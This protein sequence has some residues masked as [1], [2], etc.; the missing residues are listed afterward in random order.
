MTNWG[1]ICNMAQYSATPCKKED[2]QS[3]WETVFGD[4]RF[5]TDAFFAYAFDPDG[6]FYAERDGKAVAALYLLPVLSGDTKGFYLYAA[7]TLPA[8]RGQGLMGS[9]IREA[10]AY[11]E[12][13]AQFV[14]LCPAEDSL[15]AYY[16]RFGF[17]QTLYAACYEKA[18]TDEISD[19]QQMY[20]YAKTL[21]NCPCFLPSVYRYACLIGCKMYRCGGTLFAE[22]AMYPSGTPQPCGSVVPYG[23]A[24]TFTE[25]CLPADWYAFLTMN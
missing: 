6:C 17:S 4:S 21:T 11:A 13:N 2:L 19:A 14:Y 7:A 24:I 1:F 12:K 23:T 10:L 3:L 22:K 16:A 18:V 8:Y 20:L 5:V 9:L 15:Y 25:N